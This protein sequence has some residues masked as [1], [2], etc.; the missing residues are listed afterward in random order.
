MT[1]LE[2]LKKQFQDGLISNREFIT[3]A[4]DLLANDPSYLRMDAPACPVFGPE[5]YL[6]RL[7]AIDIK[8]DNEYY[9]LAWDIFKS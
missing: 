9:D 2:A 4:I 1:K 6:N 7:G 5:G 8:V 3:R